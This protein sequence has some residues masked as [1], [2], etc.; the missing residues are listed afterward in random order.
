MIILTSCFNGPDKDKDNLL[1]RVNK[2][3]LYK[4]EL[5]N[6]IPS[7]TSEHDSILLVRNYVNSWVTEKLILRKALNNLRK[8]DLQFDK[9]LDEYRNSLIIYKYESQLIAQS[10]DTNVTDI[11]IE[12]FY[13]ENIGNF[14]LKDNIVK[15][16]YA[17]F[18]SDLPELVKIRRFFYSDLPGHS[19]SLDKYVQRFSDLYYKD[20]ETWILFEDVIREIPITTF[21]HEVYLQSH[22]KIEI[23]KDEMVYLVNFTDFKIKEGVSPLGYEKENIRQI[24][25]NKRKLRI[26]SQMRENAYQTALK[27]NA[28]EIY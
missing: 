16:Y 20:D 10:L 19:D 12:K 17:R 25:I 27:E 9:Q 15:V 11:E 4:S 5:K 18:R 24:I 7:G 6:I 14:Q 23:S 3:Y 21:D 8:S 1:A 2:D 13:N 26:I 28:F 22:R